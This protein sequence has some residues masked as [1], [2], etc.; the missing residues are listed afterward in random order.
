[1]RLVDIPQL[2]RAVLQDGVTIGAN[3]CV[4]RG[5]YDDTII[6]EDTKLDNLVH[7][8]HNS[9][10][11]RACLAGRLYGHFSAALPSATAYYS[12]AGP[13]VADHLTIGSG[14]QIA[15]ASAMRDDATCPPVRPGAGVPAQPIRQWLRETALLRKLVQE[16]KGKGTAE[17]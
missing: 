6:G 2:G 17:E 16:G 7:V 11:G 12:A 1:M 8:A 9:R 3:S 13:G 4:D 14:A 5:A 10:L 15:A